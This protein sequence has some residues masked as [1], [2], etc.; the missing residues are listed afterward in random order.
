MPESLLPLQVFDFCVLLSSIIR[1]NTVVTKIG[2]RIY[3]FLTEVDFRQFPDL[4]YGTIL[5]T[6]QPHLALFL[7][8]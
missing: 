1:N 7:P 4:Y 6:T 5:F 3:A 2:V 8:I